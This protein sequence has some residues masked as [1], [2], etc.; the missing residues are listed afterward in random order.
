MKPLEAGIKTIK[1]VQIT[2]SDKPGVYRMLSEKGDVL[3]LKHVAWK[4]LKRI[5]N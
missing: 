4:S 1:S 5:L 2:L 3:F